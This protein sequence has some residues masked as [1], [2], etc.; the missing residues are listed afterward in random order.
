[1]HSGKCPMPCAP[2][3]GCANAGG[4]LLGSDCCCGRHQTRCR[5]GW[6]ECRTPHVRRGTGFANGCEG[7]WRFVTAS[8]ANAMHEGRIEQSQ[9]RVSGQMVGEEWEMGNGA[10]RSCG[11]NMPAKRTAQRMMSSVAGPAAG[12]TPGAATR[13][14]PLQPQPGFSWPTAVR[15]TSQ[16]GTLGQGEAFIRSTGH[17]SALLC[18]DAHELC[19]MSVVVKNEHVS[20]EKQRSC[21][22]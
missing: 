13:P 16:L 8:L 5:L 6:V 2:G 21:R 17:R 18:C 15:Q 10:E 3:N 4:R 11:V 7:E 20:C 1:M 19:A 22:T 14:P 9:R 12:P